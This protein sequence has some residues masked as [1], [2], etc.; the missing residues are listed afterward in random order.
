MEKFGFNCIKLDPNI[1]LEPNP[2]GNDGNQSNSFAKLL[3]ELQFLANCTQP[4]IAFAVNRLASY[5]A[6]LSLQHFA[7]LKQIYSIWLGQQTIVLLI[8]KPPQT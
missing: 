5:T 1:K 7:A 2:N 8:L 4:N 3:G 6:N